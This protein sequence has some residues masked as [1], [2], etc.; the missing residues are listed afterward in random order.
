MISINLHTHTSWS[1]GKNSISEML[2]S[3]RAKGFKIY[4]I[5]DHFQT[6]N[7]VEYSNFKLTVKE[8]NLK[9][10]LN[11]IEKEAEAFPELLVLKGV[12]VDY[13]SQFED[14]I[15]ATLEKY[16]LDVVI[17]SIHNILPDCFD[18]GPE[19]WEKTAASQGGAVMFYR[20]YFDWVGKAAKSGLFDIIGHLDLVKLFNK[21]ERYFSEGDAEYVKTVKKCLK[22]IKESG[23]AVEINCEGWS[24][25]AA[26]EYPSRWIFHLLKQADVDISLGGDSHDINSIDANY[27]L[28]EELL[29]EIGITRLVYFVH[30]K[31]HYLEI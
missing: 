16:D 2:Q 19:F 27:Q 15:Q 30:R 9:P 6:K 14:E 4:A 17:A 21:D 29:H 8:D 10:Y 3:A 22:A 7:A 24:K 28:A 18:N 1:D 5:T 13:Y 20:K 12:E 23:I 11:A 25:P 31:K 26:R